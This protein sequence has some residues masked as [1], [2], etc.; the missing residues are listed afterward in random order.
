GVVHAGGVRGRRVA[1][2]RV[3]D[4]G[5]HGVQRCGRAAAGAA[6]R[7][8][9][10]ADGGTGAVGGRRGASLL[11]GGAGGFRP[12]R[13]GARGQRGLG[14]E[15]AD[16]ENGDFSQA[17]TAL[18]IPGFGPALSFSRTYDAQLAQQQA[19]A[20]TPVPPGAPGSLGYGWTDKWDTWL[21]SGRTVP[22]DIYTI[23]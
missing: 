20:A 8:S 2:G 22:G 23:D 6:G 13:G 5:L 15:P 21:S 9:E 1:G 16:T 18:S 10:R 4:R 11:G 14:G 17:S 12:P 19:V 3:L 7:P